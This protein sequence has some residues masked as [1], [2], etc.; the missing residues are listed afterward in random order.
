MSVWFSALMGLVQGLTEFLPVSSSGHLVLLQ[1]FSGIDLSGNGL[2]FDV[3]LH[4]GTLVSVL[5]CFRRDITAI[6]REFFRAFG[7]ILHRKPLLNGSPDRRMLILIF[8]SSLPMLVVPFISDSIETLFSDLIV[9]GAMLIVTAL[10]L[11]IADHS[12]GRNIDAGSATWKDALIVG[13]FQLGALIPGISRS[14]ATIAGGSVRGFRRDFA[15]RYSF[16]MSVPVILG[17]NIFTL[18]DAVSEGFDSALTLPYLTGIVCAA[19]SGIAA[20]K[21]VRIIA[22]RNNFRIFSVYTAA[23]GIAAIVISFIGRL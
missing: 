22:H 14:G 3:L 1:S 6:L 11:F 16:L 23:V 13:L 19:V 17:A 18:R 15:V 7:D 21:L 20:I 9:V 4:A 8:I 5:I 10:L 2:C 12:Q